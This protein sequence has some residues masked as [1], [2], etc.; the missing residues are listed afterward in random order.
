MLMSVCTRENVIEWLKK[1]LCIKFFSNTFIL[2]LAR[3]LFRKKCF[4]ENS[5]LLFKLGI[6][7]YVTN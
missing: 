5:D 4:R 2:K 7:K 1:A 6:V 3:Q